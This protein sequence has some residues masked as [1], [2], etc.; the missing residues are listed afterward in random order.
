MIS[1]L[2]LPQKLLRNGVA[3]RRSIRTRTEGVAIRIFDKAFDLT[4]SEEVASKA[5]YEAKL[6]NPEWPGGA[7]GV[8]VGIGYDLGQTD[9]AKIDKECSYREMPRHQ[10]AHG[11]RG[12]RQD[13]WRNSPD[14]AD[15]AETRGHRS[16]PSAPM[17]RQ[18][19]SSEFR[20]FSLLILEGQ[21]DGRAYVRE[22]A[23]RVPGAVG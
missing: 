17:L 3:W 9:R 7:S 23:W 2:R 19:G 13:T 14:E 20:L 12:V 4:V 21:T 10:S 1:P 16:A 15:R 6:R 22:F 11:R 18:S 5:H 8:T